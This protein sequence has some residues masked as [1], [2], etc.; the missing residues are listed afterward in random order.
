MSQKLGLGPPADYNAE[1]DNPCPHSSNS[2]PW[3][4]ALDCRPMA[5]R[6]NRSIE[7]YAI[8]SEDGML[9]NAAGVMP[10][11]LKFEADQRFF[12]LALDD[13]A[14]VVH[15][16]HSHEGQ[17]HSSS[18]YRLVLTRRISATS[19]IPSSD[20]ALLWNPAGATLEQALILL[21]APDGSVGVIGGSEVFALFL[22]RYD[23][24]QL[25]RAPNVRLPGGRPV[26]P[27]V[28]ARTPEQVLACHGLTCRGRLMLDP[29]K[30]V[31]L[32]TWRRQS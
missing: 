24:F 16:R 10:D 11:S 1:V 17:P 15:G 6:H 2:V 29:G 14:V 25:S 18:R 12:E 31:A 32:E 27:E 13:V 20:R 4:I 26:F 30:G 8:V 5:T 9:A 21:G 23:L 19:V 22:D 3:L 7:G 28:P